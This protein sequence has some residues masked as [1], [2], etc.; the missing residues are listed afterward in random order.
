MLWTSC[1]WPQVKI[2]IQMILESH[3]KTK[4]TFSLLK[5]PQNQDHKTKTPS[6]TDLFNCHTK[7]QQPIK[8]IQSH[9]FTFN[10][11]YTKAIS[12]SFVFPMSWGVCSQ[13][14][15]N[16]RWRTRESSAFFSST[17][18]ISLKALC[19]ADKSR[20]I[21]YKAIVS[22][23][24]GRERLASKCNAVFEQRGHTDHCWIQSAL[25]SCVWSG[26]W[27]HG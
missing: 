26:L 16:K 7:T 4:A 1:L 5:R 13:A 10:H 19:K 2:Q 9:N 15:K 8:C 18:S 27:V 14:T 6:L 25:V 21:T 23:N 24:S 20:C 3:T 17:S 22:L 11:A 12:C